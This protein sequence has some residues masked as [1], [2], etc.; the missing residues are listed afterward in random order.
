MAH[1]LQPLNDLATVFGYVALWF[2][3][4]AIT[5]VA[6]TQI[7]TTWQTSRRLRQRPTAGMACLAAVLLIFVAVLVIGGLHAVFVWDM[8]AP[9]LIQR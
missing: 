8:R 5:V 2:G 6:G 7:H 1:V 9:R 4:V 3:G